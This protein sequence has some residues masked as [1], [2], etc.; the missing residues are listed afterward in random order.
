MKVIGSH[1][2]PTYDN[3]SFS[4]FYNNKVDV[5]EKKLVVGRP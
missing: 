3:T 5:E 1:D 2:M 4:I